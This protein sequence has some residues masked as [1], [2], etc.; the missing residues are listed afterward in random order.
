MTAPMIYELRRPAQMESG[1]TY[2]A[3]FLLHGIGSNEQ[4]M[5]PLVDELENQF[6]IFSIRGH[7]PQPP[8]YAFFTIEGYG[9]PH[10]T[11]FDEGVN[12]LISFLD[13]ACSKYPIDEKQIFLLGFSQG[14]ILSMTLGL[15][16]GQRIKGIVALSGYIPAFVEEEYI[17][18]S[19]EN[20]SIF[21]SHGEMDQVLPFEWGVANDEYF[22]KLGAAVTFRT[23][24]V[25]HTVSAENHQDFIKWISEQL[26]K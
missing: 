8:G 4:N 16:L 6:F 15:T 13:Y 9:K 19:V 17:I 25:G 18:K 21:I 12:K 10:R 26:E 1:K 20:L 24:P 2:P 23:Y 22:R 14:A 11:V 7:L 5:L 3:L